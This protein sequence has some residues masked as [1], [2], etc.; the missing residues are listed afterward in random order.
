MQEKD[1]ALSEQMV[2]YLCSFAKTGDPNAEGLPRWEAAGK[3]SL[4]LGE[5]ETGMYKPNTFRLLYTMFTNKAPG[6]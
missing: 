4:R 5:G 6:E 1:Y 3:R 2:S